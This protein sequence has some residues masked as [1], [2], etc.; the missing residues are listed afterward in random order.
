MRATLTDVLD[1]RRRGTSP[2]S[3]SPTS[4]RRSWRGIARRAS[5]TG[6]RS[7]GRTG[8]RPTAA[9]PSPTPAT[10]TSSAGAPA[11]CSIRTSARTKYEWL[12]DRGRRPGRRA[13]RPRHDRLLDRV[14]PHRRGSATSPTSPTPAARCCS[15]SD[16]LRLGRRALR[17]AARAAGRAARRA[18]RRPAGSATTSA[19]SGVPAGIPVSGIAGDQQAALFGQSCVAAGDGQEHLR[20]GQLRPAQRRRDVSAAGR[21]PAHDGRL[22]ARRRHDG[23][24]PR[25]G[26]L[27]HRRGGAVAARR[28]GAVQRAD[29]IGPLAESVADNGGVYVVPAFTGLGSPW[30]DPYARGTIV[31][32]TRGTTKAHLARA[33]VEAMAYQTRDVVEAMV[34]RRRHADHRAARR[35]WRQRDGRDAPVPGR[36]AR[37]RR[38]AVRSTRRRRRSARRSSPASPR[39]S[40]RPRRRSAGGG[41]SMRR[42]RRATNVR[43]STP[44]TATGCA[45]SS[46]R[47]GSPRR[48]PTSRR[49][50]R[51]PSRPQR[52]RGR[53]SRRR[54]G[55]GDAATTRPRTATW[56]RRWRRR[57]PP[58]RA[59]CGA[60]SAGRSATP[61]TTVGTALSTPAPTSAREA[62]AKRRSR[63]GR[64]GTNSSR[65]RSGG[66]SSAGCSG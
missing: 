50:N 39:A 51:R 63:G 40:S 21:R 27:R 1:R 60:A 46:A 38:S 29:E 23:L 62:A 7:C 59:A 44:A 28:T 32:I 58:R 16:A 9:T 15:T 65:T 36:P 5:R 64:A 10:S 12:L 57:A 30:W 48:K 20:H 37:G 6:G 61:A 18:C 56:P 3:A 45:P 35:R 31:G 41:P 26:D 42:S 2:R 13:P 25:G 14:E 49:G 4:A 53:A 24:R 33:V 54:R 34:G 66:R 47:V 8:A 22:D 52:R 43:P 55:G 17:P 19:R 11:S